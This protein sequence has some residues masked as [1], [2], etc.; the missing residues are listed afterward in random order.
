MKLLTPRGKK[1]QMGIATLSISMMLLFIITIAS[2]STARISITEQLVSNNL[3][4][5]KQAFEAAQASLESALDN[6]KVSFSGASPTA[7]LISGGS[8]KLNNG[9]TYSYSY[10][11]IDMNQDNFLVNI[12][13]TGYTDGGSSKRIVQ[14]SAHFIPPLINTPIAPL[15]S[16]NSIWLS[17]VNITNNTAGPLAHSGGPITA[18]ASPQGS[19][20][21]QPTYCYTDSAL[22]AMNKEEFFEYY[23]GLE[24]ILLQG[25]SEVYDC[26]ECG[27]VLDG[28]TGK[29]AWITQKSKDPVHLD[30]SNI[31]SQDEPILL[32]IDGDLSHLSNTTIYGL[33]YVTGEITSNNDNFN[34]TGALI[35]EDLATLQGNILLAYDAAV[36]ANL[37]KLGRFARIAGSW[38]DF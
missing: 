25:L 10:Q 35:T 13:A 15:T 22:T 34:I 7:T 5:E 31:G 17:N 38:R 3:Y 9:A 36:L 28:Q 2:L 16:R 26:T 12:I 29:I 27:E 33:V 11:F 20:C 23:F 14:Q 32:I 37:D 18:I 1:E 4:R 8:S 6:L 21:T 30:D 19:S 24:K